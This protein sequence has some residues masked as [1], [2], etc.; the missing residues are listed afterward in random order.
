MELSDSLSELAAIETAVRLAVKDV[1]PE[2]E[3]DYD[4]DKLQRLRAKREEESRRRDGVAVDQ[5]LLSYMETHQLF[6]LVKQHWESFK[7]VFDDKRRL[8]VLFGIILDYRNAVAHGR[9]LA[10]FEIALLEGVGGLVRNQ[11]ASIG[12]QARLAKSTT[13]LSNPWLT[14]SI[15]R[16]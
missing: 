4:A 5:S 3:A 2:W 15:E 9:E 10:R 1:L 13:R 14:R 6:E 12:G 11:V 7:P 16:A 8:E